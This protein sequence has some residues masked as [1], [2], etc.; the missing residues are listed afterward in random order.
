LRN[1]ER[2]QDIE[3]SV[4]LLS[5]DIESGSL[6]RFS[7]QSKHLALQTDAGMR[8]FDTSEV[9]YIGFRPRHG[10][11]MPLPKLEK[12]QEMIVHT[13]TGDQFR[14]QMGER[15]PHE[16]GFFVFDDNPN[17]EFDHLFFF[18]HGVRSLEKPLPIGQALVDAKLLSPEEVEKALATQRNFQSMHIGD[19]LVEQHKLEQA[20]IERAL[21]KQ[22]KKPKQIGAILIESGLIKE[23][24]LQQALQE[25]SKNQSM[26]IGEILVKM[27]LLTEVE[28]ISALADKFH[29]PFVN[30]DDYVINPAAFEQIDSALLEKF[31]VLPIDMD[32]HTLMLACANPM[33]FD[34]FDTIRFQTTKRI[35]EVLATPTQIRQVLHQMSMVDTDED[36][37]GIWIE[38]VPGD[39]EEETAYDEALELKAAEASP[40]VRLVNRILMTGIHKGASDIHLMPQSKN[41][42]LLYRINGDLQQEMELEKWVQRRV[43]SR[44]KVLSGMNITD[45]RI[46]QDGR[47]VVRHE[48]GIV[49]FRVSC[50]PNAY[51]ESIVLRVLGKE[52]ASDLQALGLSD[53]DRHQLS[54]IVRKPYGMVLATGP[55]GSGKSTTLFALVQSIIDLPLHVLTIE[56][57]VESEIEKANQ[58]QVNVKAGL[59]FANILRNVLRHD[60]DVIMVGEMRDQETATIG[61]E[62]ALTGHL[63]LSTLHTNSAVDTVIRLLDL[64]IPRYLL[65]PALRGII[66]QTLL[67]RLCEHCR[68]P[69]KDDNDDVYEMLHGLGMKRPEQLY[70]AGGCDHCNNTGFSGR[71]MAYE[72]LDVNDKVREAIHVGKIGREL[73]EIAE[74]E[75][76]ISKGRHALALAEQGIICRNDLVR[77]LI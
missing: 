71:V 62:A 58:I 64:G 68:Q 54:M 10:N 34:A 19:I 22:R 20:D 28:L 36:N 8:H 75:G 3:V 76:M 47:M 52:M 72:F 31:Q 45:H 29:L 55:T 12:L 5:C 26:K 9:A 66:S 51:G 39:E 74:S 2:Q 48:R 6:D 21:E 60:P 23:E 56:D 25:Q 77:V 67:K 57:P 11:R 41:L 59:T 63:I 33:D 7:P 35:V 38:Q 16:N 24:D 18:N 43:I 30:L 65:A 15:R 50:I 61:I 53:K 37:E 14:V 4:G 1:S 44:L 70:E 17:S 69:L 42:L 73:Q 13:T 40:I 49:E 27:G 46:T 32:E